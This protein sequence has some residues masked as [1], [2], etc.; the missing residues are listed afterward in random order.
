MLVQVLKKRKYWYYRIIAV[1][2]QILLTSETY[3]SKSNALRAA[4]DF[5][6]GVLKLGLTLE[7]KQERQDNG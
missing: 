6:E 4:K 3:Y 1:N 5:I 2:S 7:I